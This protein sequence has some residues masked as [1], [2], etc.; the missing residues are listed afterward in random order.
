MAERVIEEWT[1]YNE[2]I[3]R[4]A[5]RTTQAVEDDRRPNPPETPP[6]TTDKPPAGAS[7]HEDTLHIVVPLHPRTGP[8]SEPGSIIDHVLYNGPPAPL[9]RE[10]GP[11]I[12]HPPLDRIT[13]SSTSVIA[14][15]AHPSPPYDHPI[16]TAGE[17]N[18]PPPIPPRG[19]RMP[20]GAPEPSGPPRAPS[21]KGQPFGVASASPR[22]GVPPAPTTAAASV[23]QP[24]KHRDWTWVWIILAILLL[25]ALILSLPW[26]YGPPHPI[27]TY[28]SPPPVTTSIQPSITSPAR[29]PTPTGSEVP[30]TNFTQF[31]TVQFRGGQVVTGWNFYRNGDSYPYNQ[32]CY[33]I[34]PEDGPGETLLGAPVS[35]PSSP[36]GVTVKYDIEDRPG[37]V[38]PLPDKLRSSL[39][40][41]GWNEAR[42]KCIWHD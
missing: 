42:S 4:R 8:A 20:L 38:K 6:S 28:V 24:V 30:V 26:L 1:Y 2:I 40:Q 31:Q 11:V 12:D 27:M 15:A 3:L 34:A 36:K 10:A 18:V 37:S 16:R 41:Q 25:I 19:I 33:Y 21:P 35:V 13:S 39:G 14:G 5:V 7:A 23:V 9:R 32:Y 29:P 22:A 17:G